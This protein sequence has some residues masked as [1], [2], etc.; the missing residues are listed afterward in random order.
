MFINHLISLCCT[1]TFN[2]DVQLEPQ[3]TFYPILWNEVKPVC[4]EQRK[5]ST[6]LR[7][8][9]EKESF[10]VHLNNKVTSQFTKSRD[11]TLCRWILNQ[12]CIFC[13]EIV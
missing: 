4:F 12:F 13:D 9:I 10:S 5:K 6:A 11:G 3:S 2:P 1:R 7:E 8:L